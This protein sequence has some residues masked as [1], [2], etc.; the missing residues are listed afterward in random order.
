MPEQLSWRSVGLTETGLV[1]KINEDALYVSDP[2]AHWAVADGM[3][4]HHAGDLASQL[5]V[6]RLDRLPLDASLSRRV[7]HLEDALIQANQELVHMAG[8][9]GKVIGTTVAGLMFDQGRYLVYWCG[10]SRV[11][12]FRNGCLNQETVDHTLVQ[13]LLEQ[14]RINPTDVENHPERNV[15]TRAVGAAPSLYVDMDLRP[16]QAGDL[17]LIC[18]D[19]LDKEISELE[20]TQIL[21]IEGQSLDQIAG[22]LMS[23]CLN[24][25]AKDNITLVVISVEET[26]GIE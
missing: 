4:G 10:D 26:V 7:D 25:T 21:G 16:L 19:G 1:R 15:I 11:Y 5:V 3:G 2:K 23:T 6:E 20:L 14:G 12:L 18:S 8:G 17:F 22:R 13:E 24:R 9:G